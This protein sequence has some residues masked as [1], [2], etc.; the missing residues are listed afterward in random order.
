MNMRT[1]KKTWLYG[2]V[3]LVLG[4][5]VTALTTAPTAAKPPPEGPNK[6]QGWNYI[7]GVKEGGKT[8]AHADGRV[9]YQAQQGSPGCL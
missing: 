5:S 1:M 6:L 9:I 3:A 2:R 8:V 7:L 4:L